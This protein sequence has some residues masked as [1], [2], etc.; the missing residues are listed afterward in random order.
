[1]HPQPLSLSE[2]FQS[3]VAGTNDCSNAAAATVAQSM[4]SSLRVRVP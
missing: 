1:M 3:A 4:S 2:T